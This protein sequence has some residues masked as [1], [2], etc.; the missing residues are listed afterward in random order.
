MS[1][2][3]PPHLREGVSVQK[4]TKK[5]V[6][7]RVRLASIYGGYGGSPGVIR[8]DEADGDD[9]FY[10]ELDGDDG[11]NSCCLIVSAWRITEVLPPA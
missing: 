9:G 2:V 10:V 6:G 4:V 11:S 1:S 5:H 3:G 8:H 7:L